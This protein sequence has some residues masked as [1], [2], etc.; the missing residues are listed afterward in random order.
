MGTDS[1]AIGVV[2]E[3][4]ICEMDRAFAC[5]LILCLQVAL[6]RPFASFDLGLVLLP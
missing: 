1:V 2:R 4:Q 6:Q 3:I 5:K